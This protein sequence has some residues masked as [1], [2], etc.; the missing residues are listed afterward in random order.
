MKTL[1]VLTL[2]LGIS[3]GAVLADPTSLT[4]HVTPERDVVL[5]GSAP[6]A[7]VEIEIE[8]RTPDHAERAPMNLA[9]VLDRS[10]SMSGAK[11][12]KA[13][14]GACA[15]IDQMGPNDFV[16]MVVYDNNPQ[17][18]FPPQHATSAAERDDLKARIYHIQPGGGTAIYAGLQ[19]GAAQLRKHLDHEHLSRIILLSDGIANV[20]PSKV[21]DLAGLASSLRE[22]QLSV[23]TIGLGDDYNEDLMTAVAEASHA[24]YYYVQDAEKLPG[25]LS[26]EL[27]AARTVLAR[28][29][30]VRITAP[31]GVRI[32]EIIG[33]PEVKCEGRSAEISMSEYFG[34]DK[35]RFIARCAFDAPRHE[36]AEAAAVT[37]RYEDVSSG[38]SGKL[39]GWAK[40]K[41]TDDEKVSNESQRAEIAKHISVLENRAA[42]ELAVKLADD[43]KAKE[44]AVVLRNQAAKN[45]AAAPAAQIPN[46]AEENSK[47]ESSAAE[48]ASQGTLS[49]SSRKQV[50]YENW[51][52]KYQ[53]A[54]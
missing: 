2:L 26:E 18:L 51:Q 22:E 19:M 24:N 6:E 38:S 20:G 54:R 13:R 52:D 40:V 8:G 49:K 12:E 47:L 30:T 45:E 7:L 46:L 5:N 31:E 10:G 11:I 14:Q 15:A 1:S 3:A 23:S 27:G 41:F 44:A 32:R 9:I 25:I 21:S 36:T 35:R 43:G 34:A 39:D 48:I 16:S 28:G 37:L 4:L 29:V 42:K 53:K 33:H 50:Q 17:V